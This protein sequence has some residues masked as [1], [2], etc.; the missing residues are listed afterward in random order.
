MKF[1]K[2]EG[3]GDESDFEDKDGPDAKPSQEIWPIG[4]NLAYVAKVLS[5]H[6]LELGVA[7]SLSIPTLCQ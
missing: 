1:Y 5:S 4:L 2:I 7:S 3:D 6:V